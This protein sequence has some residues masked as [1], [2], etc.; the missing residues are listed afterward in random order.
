MAWGEWLVLKSQAASNLD[1]G[2]LFGS[3]NETN[4]QACDRL[5]KG[6]GYEVTC[7]PPQSSTFS[8][9][10]SAHMQQPRTPRPRRV[11]SRR[12]RKRPRTPRLDPATA[13]PAASFDRT[14]AD[15]GRIRSLRPRSRLDHPAANRAS[16]LASSSGGKNDIDAIGNRKIGGGKLGNWYSLEKEIQM[17]KGYAQQVES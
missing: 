5:A 1:S 3:Y 4:Q 17:G 13:N 10:A 9:C 11:R 16:T 6:V 7:V 2:T 12:S 8:V 14:G 15:S